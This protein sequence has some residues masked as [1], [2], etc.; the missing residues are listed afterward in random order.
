LIYAVLTITFM[1]DQNVTGLTLS[2]FGVGFSNFVGEF[3]LTNFN[4]NSLKLPEHITAQ[5]SN[6]S[7]SGLSNI[8]VIGSLL[9]RYDPFVI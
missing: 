6:I 4:T 3:M 7:I 9:F 1:A 2:I 8:P 5:I